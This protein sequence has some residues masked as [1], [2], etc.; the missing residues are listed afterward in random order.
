MFVAKSLVTMIREKELVTAGRPLVPNDWDRVE[1]TVCLSKFPIP[2]P[3]EIIREHLDLPAN[4]NK[5]FSFRKGWQFGIRYDPGDAVV[6]LHGNVECIVTVD[7]FIQWNEDGIQRQ[8]LKTRAWYKYGA[9]EPAS[10]LATLVTAAA[11]K[12]I[13]PAESIARKLLLFNISGSL[14]ACELAGHLPY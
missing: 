4:V 2:I 12:L 1:H 3:L 10:G 13:L 9:T 7:Y 8:A 5:I 6:V 11:H 14:L